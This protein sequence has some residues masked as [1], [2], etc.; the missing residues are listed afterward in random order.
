MCTFYIARPCAAEAA[1][2]REPAAAPIAEDARLEQNLYTEGDDSILAENGWPVQVRHAAATLQPTSMRRPS[3]RPANAPY[4][5]R[6]CGHMWS[7]CASRPFALM[8]LF[9][10]LIAGGTSEGGGAVAYPVMVRSRGCSRGV[11]TE[12]SPQSFAPEIRPELCVAMSCFLGPP[13]LRKCS[14]DFGLRAAESGPPW[15]G[16]GW[17][18]VNQGSA[19]G[20]GGGI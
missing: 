20:R 19:G 11:Y 18:G 3:A 5:S 14:S 16:L 9:G 6:T 13:L 12:E 10:S 7:T 4:H 1:S 15:L 17:R 8:M 2:Q